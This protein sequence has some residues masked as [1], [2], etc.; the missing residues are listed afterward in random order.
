MSE[1]GRD[2]LAIVRISVSIGIVLV[3]SGMFALPAGTQIDFGLTH[4]NQDPAPPPSP[5][6]VSLVPDNLDFGDQV[7]RR[8]S[9]AKRITVKNTG[10][11]PLY[12]DSVE[13]SGDNPTAFAVLKDTCTGATVDPN[14]ACIVDVTF[15]PSATGGRN[16]RLKLS[17]NALDSPQ[18]LKLKGNGINSNDVP[19]F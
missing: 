7:V 6:Y 12:F 16:A 19:P 8:T 17:D 18:R 9:A 10:G 14:K 5:P 3:V 13:L 1:T 2:R 15:T 4:A 11:Q